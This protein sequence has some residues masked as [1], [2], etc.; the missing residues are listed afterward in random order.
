MTADDIQ[1]AINS[2]LIGFI[3]FDKGDKSSW[4][5]SVWSVSKQISSKLNMEIKEVAAKEKESAASENISA[6]IKKFMANPMSEEEEAQALKAIYHMN[7][8][9][10]DLSPQML[11][12]IDKIIGV[13][14]GKDE[15]IQLVDF[16]DAFPDY[17]E[18]IRICSQPQP[19]VCECGG[20]IK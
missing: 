14:K 17:A 12:K 9:S 4:N 1:R 8:A 20:V 3:P 11:E 10:G 16:S 19:K 13:G 6:Q 5:K 2:E 18:A 7:L 15:E